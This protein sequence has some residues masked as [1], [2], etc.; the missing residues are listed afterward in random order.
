[1]QEREADLKIII[2]KNKGSDIPS[3]V[4]EQIISLVSDNTLKP[5]DKLPSELEMTRRFNISRI[6]LREALKL[7]EAKGYVVSRGRRGKFICPVT[8]IP[9]A[10]TLDAM[11]RQ[12]SKNIERIS[13]V[14]EMVLRESA[15]IAAER[16]KPEHLDAMT[17]AVASLRDATPATYLSA[18][19]SFLSA[20]LAAADNAIITHLNQTLLSSLNAISGEK[21][22]ISGQM[23]GTRGE[24]QRQTN[25]IIEAIRS[26]S[27]D[28]A[29]HAVIEHFIHLRKNITI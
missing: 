3:L 12:D 15:A 17:A 8:D 21:E 1:M 13:E 6:S 29:R 26:G 18:H 10:P 7:L 25:S 20:I 4:V 19:S 23:Y 5:G 11:V 16:A 9:L 27:A 28:E 24:I 14:R 2:R 22:R